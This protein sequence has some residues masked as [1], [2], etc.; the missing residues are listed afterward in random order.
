MDLA[1]LRADKNALLTELES[2]GAKIHK[3]GK[4]ILCPFHDDHTPSGDVYKAED[5]AWRF[6]CHTDSCGFCGDIFDVMAKRQG[7]RVDSLLAEMATQQEAG[8]EKQEQAEKPATTYPDL[9]T[10]IAAVNFME[11]NDEGRVVATY[12]YTNPQTKNHDLVVFRVQ[13]PD[14]KVFK[15]AHQTPRG[16][17]LKA[18]AGK[19]P[20]YNRSRLPDAELVVVVEGEKCVHALHEIGVV[21]TTSPGGA[22]KAKNADWTPLAGKRVVVWPDNDPVDPKTGK[23]TG[24]EHARGVVAELERLDPAPQISVI[25]PDEL[26]IPPKGDAVEYLEKYKDHTLEE[27]RL[28]V[29]AICEFADATGPAA[30]L[31]AEVKLAIAGKRK[32]IPWKFQASGNLT[33]SLLPGAVE[34]LCGPPGSTK[35]FWLL[36]RLAEIHKRGAKVGIL[37]LEENRAYHLARAWAQEAGCAELTKTEWLEQNPEEA[38]RLYQQHKAFLDSFG[39][40]IFDAPTGELKPEMLVE[41]VHERAKA[42]CR[43]IAIDPITAMDAGREQWTADLNFLI[44]CK[45]IITDFGASLI[46]VTHPKKGAKTSGLDDLAGGAAYQRFAQTVGWLEF[47]EEQEANFGKSMGVVRETYNRQYQIRK[48]RNSSGLGLRVGFMFD[49]A[50]FCSIERGVIQDD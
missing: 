15:Q 7:K 8:K 21:A 42:G 26:E 23:R 13:R 49:A 36:E 22:G 50:T 41:W 48:A 2:A 40:C 47:V 19:L 24:L 6:K 1:T 34:I 14:K 45:R 5:R 3:E 12:K 18:P 29:D 10:L 9:D 37:E 28:A 4:E 38:A 39:R 20:L 16:Y 30:E 46:L 44:K 11:H 17:V 43:V 31:W 32:P 35:S 33:R 27:R 25:N